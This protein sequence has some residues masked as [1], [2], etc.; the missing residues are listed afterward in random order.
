MMDH[1]SQAVEISTQISEIINFRVINDK[2]ATAGQPTEEQLQHVRDKGYE[3]VVNIAPYDSRYS[4]ENEQEAISALNMEYIHLPVDFNNPLVEDY[5]RFENILYNLGDK[6]AFIHCAANYRV[7]VFIS[8]FAKKYLAW[9]EQQCDDHISDIWDIH[10]FPIWAS[11][12][13]QLRSLGSTEQVIA[14]LIGKHLVP[15]VNDKFGTTGKSALQRSLARFIKAD[16]KIQFI[17]PGFPCKSPNKID[18]TFG[19]LPDMGEYMA[20]T[21]LDDICDEINSIYPNGCELT[22]LSD[23]TTFSDIVNVSEA[24]KD[25]YRSSLRHHAI[26][27]NIKW[28]D[29]SIFFDESMSPIKQRLQLIKQA[30]TKVKSLEKFI[31]QINTN[32]SLQAEHDRWCSYLYNDMSLGR[33]SEETRDEFLINLSN[34]AYQV[35]HRSKAL[36]DNIEQ[37]FTDH[38][39][40]SIHHY[41]NAGPKYTIALTDNS[42]TAIAPWHSV[43]LLESSGVVKLIPHGEINQTY[44]VL[45]KYQKQNWMYML[46]D[47]PQ[48]TRYSYEIVQKPRIGLVIRDT[49]NLGLENLPTSFLEKMSTLFGFVVL[50]GVPFDTVDNFAKYSNRFGE[51]YQ[52]D[53]GPVHVITAD[54]E[55]SGFVHSMEK[56]PLHWDLSM[57]PLDHKLVVENELF[58][59]HL[60]LLYCKTPSNKG[61]G[62]TNVI[63]SRSA[64]RL[65]G[66][67]NITRWKQTEVT[68]YTKMTYFGGEPRTYRLIWNHPDTN[69]Y[70]LRYQEGS[71][72]DIQQFQ[73]SSN[74]LSEKEFTDLIQE[75]NDT[76]YDK[77]CMISYEWEANDL[78]LIDNYYTLHGRQPMINRD[79]ELWRVQ[80]I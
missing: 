25:S 48:L 20:L 51:I 16:E 50:K 45:V 7:S 27:H 35:M 3:V 4:L 40:L 79:R 23:G 55:P 58:C 8:H 36:S 17:L 19:T 32:Q 47:D 2:I 73:L 28:V 31:K 11:Y 13:E 37:R 64:L 66:S 18:K 68:Y 53:F 65:A 74:Q 78:L 5:Q 52:W 69:E 38:I 39:R 43:P 56:L 30:N 62:E 15:H 75:L 80:V 29:L 61:G 67:K 41:D 34:K 42:K 60:I 71:D 26:T 70:I 12:V 9:N 49:N 22:I 44:S 33:L 54:E 21:H 6:K 72:L 14:E 46:V 57:L 76:V 59:N 77:R 10:E 63:D 1:T 24:E